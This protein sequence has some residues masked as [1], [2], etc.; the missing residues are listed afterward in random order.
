[1]IWRF[2]SLFSLHIWERNSTF[3][4]HPPLLS[5]SLCLALSFFKF[6]SKHFFPRYFHRARKRIVGIIHQW[7]ISLLCFRHSHVW[8]A[9]GTRW[10]LRDRFVLF[11]GRTSPYD[12]DDGFVQSLLTEGL[13]SSESLVCS[14]EWFSSWSGHCFSFWFSS[15]SEQEIWRSTTMRVRW[16]SARFCWRSNVDSAGHHDP[17]YLGSAGFLPALQSYICRW[18]NTCQNQSQTTDPFNENSTFVFLS[19]ILWRVHLFFCV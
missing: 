16:P 19:S 2:L 10:A 4:R 15:G 8:H 6:Q 17:K 18:N 9:L 11:Y 1:M 13:T 3:S 12:V 14:P 7:I 5:L